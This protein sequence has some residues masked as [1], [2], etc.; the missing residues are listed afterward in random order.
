MFKQDK[1]DDYGKLYNENPIAGYLDYRD[2][3]DIG[4][5]WSV[6]EG[7]FLDNK[8]HGYGVLTFSTD[9]KY[10]GGFI[11]DLAEGQGSF[12]TKDRTIYGRWDKGKLL[13]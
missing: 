2:L 3:S 11:N 4:D 12:I 5:L 8:K 13:T 1:F 10:S 7:D 9:E 6:Y